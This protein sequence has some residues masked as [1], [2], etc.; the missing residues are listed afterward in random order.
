MRHK[1]SI[2]FLSLHLSFFRSKRRYLKISKNL[3]LGIVCENIVH[4]H[5]LPHE[6][7]TSKLYPTITPRATIKH[8][9][10]SSSH[11]NTSETWSPVCVRPSSTEHFF[12]NVGSPKSILKDVSWQPETTRLVKYDVGPEWNRRTL[13]VCKSALSGRW[14]AIDS[15]FAWKYPVAPHCTTVCSGRPWESTSSSL[16]LIISGTTSSLVS[17]MLCLKSKWRWITVNCQRETWR[18]V[19]LN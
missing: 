6:L 9:N 16:Q 4:P 3:F 13:Y 8:M 14:Y 11:K 1:S 5:D 12:R 17:P 10:I 19:I 7:V 15:L 2:A 18:G